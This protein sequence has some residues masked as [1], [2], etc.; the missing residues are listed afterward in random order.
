[1]SR[2]VAEPEYIVQESEKTHLTENQLACISQRLLDLELSMVLLSRQ[3][4]SLGS[5][6]IRIGDS[7]RRVRRQLEEDT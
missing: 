6:F 5:T 1:M 2:Q 4:T 7:L 3:H